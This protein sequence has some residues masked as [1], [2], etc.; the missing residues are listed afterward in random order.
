MKT[1]DNVLIYKDRTYKKS[2]ETLYSIEV[3]GDKLR[4]INPYGG[5]F[6]MKNKSRLNKFSSLGHTTNYHYYTT[7]V[8]GTRVYL[9][10]TKRIN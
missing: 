4:V 7:V 5:V 8:N 9:L 6:G 1:I 3:E 10:L 2:Y